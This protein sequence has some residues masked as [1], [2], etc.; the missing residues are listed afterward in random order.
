MSEDARQNL[1]GRLSPT[2]IALGVGIAVIALITTILA[3]NS[4][5]NITRM[6]EATDAGYIITDISDVQR[7][8]FRL[9]VAL[10]EALLDPEGNFDETQLRRD[11]LANQLRLALTEANGDS[12]ITP[13]LLFIQTRLDTFDTLPTGLSENST[14]EQKQTA[15]PQFEQLFAE[16][17]E[18]IIRVYYQE[19]NLLFSTI[20]QVL[21]TQRASQTVVLGLIVLLLLLNVALALSLRHTIS[22]D[23]KKAYNLLEQE[24]LER[25]QVE[26]ELAV[27]RDQALAA[28]RFK[29]EILAKVSHE[30]R[31]PLNAI[32]GYTELL[33]RG[34]YGPISAK[35]QT[36]TATVI[37][38]TEY[39]TQIVGE[40][41]DQAQFDAQQSTLQAGTFAPT[42]V[43]SQVFTKMNILAQ[44]KGLILTT[45]IAEDM[46]GLVYGDA[47][48]V[49]QILMNLTSNAVKF[50]STGL[51]QM[52]IF[53]VNQTQWA[54]QVSDTGPG[55]PAEAQTYIFEPFRQVD[56]SITRTNTGSGLGL[57]IV[58]NLTELMNGQLTVE[59][60]V[61]RGS[62][63][64]VR[65]PLSLPSENIQTVNNSTKKISRMR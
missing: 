12:R 2:Q 15:A 41:L 52:N 53:R 28:S 16:M 31:T 14:F 30:L 63:F 29:F 3:V 51:V 24:L 11:L 56:G 8:I 33:N 23:F 9:H 55:I 5:L 59:S 57:S 25:T 34:I 32:L 48:R 47:Q 6:T 4:Y 36:I 17:E 27:A 65:L 49:Q 42:D 10:Q 7:G 61:G 20:S 44:E 50:T 43:V 54:I 21:Q 22:R 39:L 62:C 18:E 26:Q 45:D 58:K 64:T 38:S 35:Q 37:E 19:E 46:P 13:T 40:L 1:A 60:E